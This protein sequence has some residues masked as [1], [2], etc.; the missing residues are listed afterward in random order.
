MFSVLKNLLALIFADEPAAN[1]DDEQET[2]EYFNY[3][4]WQHDPTPTADG[5]YDLDMVDDDFVKRVRC[6]SVGP[7]DGLD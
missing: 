2:G 1:Q 3:M 7:S 4:T 6:E 5:V